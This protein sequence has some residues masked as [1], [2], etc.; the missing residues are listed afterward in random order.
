MI[1]CSEC[2]GHYKREVRAY[3][4][5][6]FALIAFFLLSTPFS[7]GLIS[8]SATEGWGYNALLRGLKFLYRHILKEK[9]KVKCG[10][11]T[12]LHVLGVIRGPF[13]EELL[14]NQ[15][16]SASILRI[17]I[18]LLNCNPHNGYIACYPLI[19]SET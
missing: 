13:P 11:A 7:P 6:I 2:S 4:V 3:V 19:S 5:I 10:M 14:T 17:N 16:C 12:E 18:S 1:C 8:L 15:R 9:K